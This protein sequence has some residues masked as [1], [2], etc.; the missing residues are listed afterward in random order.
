MNVIVPMIFIRTRKYMLPAMTVEE[1]ITLSTKY[2][3][4]VFSHIP[5][6]CNFKGL[7]YK[8]NCISAA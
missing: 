8:D 6:R 7:T 2:V 4:I 5:P 1:N 3:T